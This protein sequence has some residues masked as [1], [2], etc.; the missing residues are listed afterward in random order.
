MVC[1]IIYVDPMIVYYFACEVLSFNK[2]FVGSSTPA[3]ISIQSNWVL[4]GA[5]LNDRAQNFFFGHLP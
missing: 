4:F 5:K 3:R 2:F 1:A